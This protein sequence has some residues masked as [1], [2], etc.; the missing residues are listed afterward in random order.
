MAIFSASTMLG[1]VISPIVSGFLSASSLGWR[2]SFWVCAIL[3]GVTYLGVVL[4]PE[5]FA[6]TILRHRAEKLRKAGHV[7]VVAPS[8]LESRSLSSVFS[9]TL[10]RPFRM[11]G[12]EAIVFSTSLFLSL[13]Y[14]KG[15][16][17]FLCTRTKNS[18]L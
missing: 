4:C 18:N 9:T 3:A 10:T 12:Q 2:M 1:P 8:E 16:E 6:P 13:I 14:G 5:T 15:I 17:L 7:N 11:L